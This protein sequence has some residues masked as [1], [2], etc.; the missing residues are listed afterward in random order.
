MFSRELNPKKKQAWLKPL[1]FG[2]S[3]DGEDST[4]QTSMVGDPT[5]YECDEVYDRIEDDRKKDAAANLG[6]S[7]N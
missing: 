3:S 4:H 1:A 5:I 7:K 6:T 2:D